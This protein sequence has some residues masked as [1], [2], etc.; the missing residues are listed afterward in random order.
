[1]GIASLSNF[2]FTVRN[3]TTKLFWGV[4]LLGK[5]LM[6]LFFFGMLQTSYSCGQMIHLFSNSVPGFG[7]IQLLL[8]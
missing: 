8:P 1:M 5:H 4:A 6:Y 7:S 2:F 3:K